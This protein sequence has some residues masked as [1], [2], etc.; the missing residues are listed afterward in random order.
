MYLIIKFEKR[1]DLIKNFFL[2]VGR[3]RVLER[4]N[5]K[6]FSLLLDKF[7]VKGETILAVEY[8]MNFLNLFAK[9]D[10][11]WRREKFIKEQIAVAATVL[12]I[13]PLLF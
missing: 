11:D 13:L 8:W 10:I 6:C 12:W 9:R 3:I 5:N 2:Q 1:L 7:G 4:S